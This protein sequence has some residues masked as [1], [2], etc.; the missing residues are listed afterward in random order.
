MSPTVAIG[1]HRLFLGDAYAIRPT[2][3][4][5]DADI[6]DPPYK[7]RAEGGGPYRKARP[8]FDQIVDEELHKDFDRS[9]I[10]PLQCGGAV[11][12]ASN[13]QLAD[14][15]AHL[16]GNFHRHALL[17]WQKPNPQPIANKSYRSDVEFYCHAWRR[18]HHPIGTLA[19][20]LR[21]TT[22]GAPRRA[23]RFGHA[24]PKPDILMN[25]IVANV[26]GETICDPFMGTGST[27]V[28]AIRAGRI[29]TGIEHNPKHFETAVRRCTAA[30]EERAA[31]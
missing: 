26:A 24:T 1:P 31:A 19:E 4:W 10:N 20:K 28:A 12:F 3:G 18:D 22:I 2:L 23:A 5:M 17:V 6:L 9:I 25:K 15:L 13:D 30:W 11:V 7:M 8:H 21:V 29:F 16:R 27:G 14:L